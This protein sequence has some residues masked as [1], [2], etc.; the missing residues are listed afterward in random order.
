[1]TDSFS[2]RR[3]GRLLVTDLTSNAKKYSMWLGLIVGVIVALAVIAIIGNSSIITSKTY[4]IE[5]Y[6]SLIERDPVAN[7]M[8]DIFYFSLF[9]TVTVAA[10]QTMQNL[11]T[12]TSRINALML[13]A[14]QLEK[15]LSR[16]IIFIPLFLAAFLLSFQV[17]EWARVMFEMMIFGSD[18][19]IHS[20]NVMWLLFPEDDAERDLI[21]LSIVFLQ[22]IFVL[23][24]TIWPSNT[25]VKTVCALFV[26]GVGLTLFGSLCGNILL[27]SRYNYTLD[28]SDETAWTISRS[29]VSVFTLINYIIAY[30]RYKEIEIIQRW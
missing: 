13:P 8:Q 20:L 7:F 30:F 4:H 24:S 2:M 1:M 29:L 25:L 22:S 12:K 11:S 23:G 5:D 19:N 21:I 10:S 17:I 3:F 26:A 28:I 14:T 27:D 18:A 6:Y 15:F 9:I 16:W